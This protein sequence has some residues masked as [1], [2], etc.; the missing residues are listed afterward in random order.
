MMWALGIRS[1]SSA[2]RREMACRREETHR[3]RATGDRNAAKG[4]N[5]AGRRGGSYPPTRKG[6]NA[7]YGLL[8]EFFMSCRSFRPRPPRPGGAP[9][10]PAGLGIIVGDVIV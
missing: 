5:N 4:P 7:P 1:R 10:P 3:F 9:L 6:K 2:S 8:I